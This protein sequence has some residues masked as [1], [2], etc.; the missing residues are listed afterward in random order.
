MT[1][2]DTIAKC[3][4]CGRTQ[5]ETVLIALT[6]RNEAMWICPQHMPVLIHDP[7][8]LVGKLAGAEGMSPG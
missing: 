4:A 1:E 5:N 6:Y 3:L 2:T 7:Q 8:S